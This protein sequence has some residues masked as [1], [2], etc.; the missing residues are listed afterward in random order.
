MSFGPREANYPPAAQPGTLAGDPG[1]YSA[2]IDAASAKRAQELANLLNWT[3]QLPEEGTSLGLEECLGTL[4][5]ADRRAAIGAYWRTRES[6]ARYQL[7]SHELDQMNAVAT[8]A[9]AG[10]DRPRGAEAMLQVH[11]AQQSL[12]AAQVEA[13]LAL[14]ADQ[15]ALTQLTRRPLADHWVLA[16]T[17]PHGGE[18][19]LKADAQPQSIA[20]S[21]AF[22]RATAV[23]PALHRCLEEQ[24]EAVVLADA[25]RAA[26]GAAFEAGQAPVEQLLAAFE[27]EATATQSFLSSLTRYNTEIAGYALVVL[28][29]QSPAPMLARALVTQAA[30]APA[31]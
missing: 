22:R 14:V 15:F 18:Y 9:L 31:K 19:R 27:R 17:S 12:K 7:L 1:T 5:D 21:F 30:L 25:S 26:Y 11:Y 16:G 13:H 24:A 8:A 4:S 23:V 28:P 3:R 29:P 6:M 10:H 20:D 2:L